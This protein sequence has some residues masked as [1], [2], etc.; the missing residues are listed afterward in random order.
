MCVCVYPKCEYA[1]IKDVNSIWYETIT[2]IFMNDHIHKYLAHTHTHLHAHVHA[3]VHNVH[4]HSIYAKTVLQCIIHKHEGWPCA[5]CILTIM[6][7]HVQ[8][9]QITY[10]VN[11]HVRA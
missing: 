9:M 2:M 11:V 1:H 8:Y 5:L 4:V 10:K 3:N 6:Y 7:T